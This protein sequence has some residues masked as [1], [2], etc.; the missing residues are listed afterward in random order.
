MLVSTVLVILSGLQR[1]YDPPEESFPLTEDW[2][3]YGLEAM[4]EPLSVPFY[5]GG[6]REGGMAPGFYRA[7]TRFVVPSLST[8][9]RI[10]FPSLKG[11]GVRLSVNGRSLAVQGDLASGNA[12]REDTPFQAI[13]PVELLSDQNRII[14]DFYSLTGFGIQKVPYCIPEDKAGFRISLMFFLGDYLPVLTIGLLFTLAIFLLIP[15]VRLF[16]QRK[17][18]ISMGITLLLMIISAMEFIHSD[19]LPVSFLTYNK[20]FLSA[21]RVSYAA[22]LLAVRWLYDDELYSKVNLKK[23]K[24]V[25]LIILILAGIEI[26]LALIILIYPFDIISLLIFS[27]KTI[28]LSLPVVVTS[29]WL[30]L[31]RSQAHKQLRGIFYGFIVLLITGIYD[32]ISNNLGNGNIHFT[33]LGTSVFFCTLAWDI[34]AR[35]VANFSKWDVDKQKVEHFR[36]ESITDPLTGASNRKMLSIMKNKLSGRYSLI[37]LDLDNFKVLNDTYGHPF[38]DQVLIDLVIL[39]QRH[40]REGDIIIRMGGDEFLLILPGCHEPEAR[41]LAERLLEE[42]KGHAVHSANL[43]SGFSCSM[44]IAGNDDF[45]YSF[46][47]IM[48]KADEHLYKAKEHKGGFV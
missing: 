41:S 38:G 40:I 3:I 4:K 29:V 22:L 11:N 14:L 43:S 19:F 24:S 45:E 26:V 17:I 23:I 12:T 7:T 27:N 42:I 9:L 6:E 32:S 33:F 35:L 20:V 21:G 1:L 34:I 48:K 44:G 31:P 10:V 39:V 16:H 46:D 25:N 28:L 13:I 37:T 36:N 47:E 8:P 2:D 5:F 18:G 30:S 15:G